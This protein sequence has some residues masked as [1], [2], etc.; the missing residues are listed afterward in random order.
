MLA[1]VPTLA[2]IPALAVVELLLSLRIYRV[3]I[4]T[5]RDWWR[6]RS[7]L[8]SCADDDPPRSYPGLHGCTPGVVIQGRRFSSLSRIH[9][10]L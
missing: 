4:A 6:A 1:I 10:I 5:K 7:L 2:V 8:G 3:Y 9:F